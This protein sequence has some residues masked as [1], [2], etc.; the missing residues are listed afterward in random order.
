MSYPAYKA[1]DVS[2]EGFDELPDDSLGE[3]PLPF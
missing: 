2:A 3:L 1:Q